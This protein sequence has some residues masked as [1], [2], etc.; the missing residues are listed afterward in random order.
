VTAA[1]RQAAAAALRVADREL[2]LVAGDRDLLAAGAM[3]GLAI[4]TI[5]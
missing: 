3:A 2:I 1:Y 4:A 5:D